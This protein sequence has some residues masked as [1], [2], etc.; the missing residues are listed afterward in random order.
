MDPMKDLERLAIH[1]RSARPPLVHVAPHVLRSLR[2]SPEPSDRPLALVA[3]GSFV[4]ACAAAAYTFS[5]VNL[6]TDPLGAL[7]QIAGP[8]MP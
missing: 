3:A 1:A 4:A 5:L 2:Q 6:I 8:M 7:F